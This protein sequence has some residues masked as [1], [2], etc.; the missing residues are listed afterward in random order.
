MFIIKSYLFCI[1]LYFN[2][3]W[4]KSLLY[5]ENFILYI[6]IKKIKNGLHQMFLE[7][8]LYQ[9]MAIQHV[10]L[11]IVCIYLA[12]FKSSLVN[13]LEIYIC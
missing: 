11:I 5:N 3:F 1:C 2:C 10:L 6:L 13:L 8:N 7:I 12:D 9:E 4:V